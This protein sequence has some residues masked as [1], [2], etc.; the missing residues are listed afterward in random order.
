MKVLKNKRLK[1]IATKNGK[2]NGKTFCYQMYKIRCNK[3]IVAINKIQ[4]VTVIKLWS[5]IFYNKIVISTKLIVISNN[6]Y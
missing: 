5:Q 3:F 2:I 6:K 1:F 4:Y